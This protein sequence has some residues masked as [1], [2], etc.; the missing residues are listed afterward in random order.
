MSN[1]EKKAPEDMTNE[2][3]LT[4]ISAYQEGIK[5]LKKFIKPTKAAP[6]A[7]LVESNKDMRTRRAAEFAKKQEEKD[8][9]TAALVIVGQNKRNAK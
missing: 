2:E 7:T 8:A 3:L 1:V 5:A 4:K 6:I 9:I